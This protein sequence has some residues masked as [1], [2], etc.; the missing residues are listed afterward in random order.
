M[1]PRTAESNQRIR[2]ER[3]VQ[4]LAAA[5][6]VFARQGFAAAK[7]SDIAA[8][9]GVSYGLVDH[10]FGK[11]EDVY[12]AVVADALQGGLKFLEDALHRP[13][14]PWERLEGI[15]AAML[16]GLRD[17]PE[18]VWIVN[19]A[20]ANEA[21]P[22]EIQ[23]LFQTYTQKSLEI[24]V[25]LIR[26]GQAAGQVVAGNP[27]ELAVAFSAAIQGLAIQSSDAYLSAA[28]RDHFPSP[29]TILRILKA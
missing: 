23:G 18:Y 11:K 8:E 10:Y 2:D 21:I 25:E 7:I 12:I 19:Q 6:R 24:Q 4:I 26:Q 13:G 28:T 27:V 16:A 5:R 22:P 14:T 9:A 17:E 15:C 1:S 20:G 29:A 3:Q